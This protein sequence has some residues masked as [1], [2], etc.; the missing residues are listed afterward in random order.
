MSVEPPVGEQVLIRKKDGK[1]IGGIVISIRSRDLRLGGAF[2]V[3]ER[4]DE[5]G[6]V[7]LV[8]GPRV[9]NVDIPMSAI[10]DWEKLPQSI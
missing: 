6:N 7:K 10:T 4:R 2:K 9:G 8:R 5:T 1:K 3:E